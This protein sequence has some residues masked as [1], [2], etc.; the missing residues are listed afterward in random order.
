MPEFT[1]TRNAA[2]VERS[3]KWDL[4]AAIADDAVASALPITSMESKLAAKAAFESV[5]VDYADTTIRDLCTTAR[6]DHDATDEQR[7][8]WRP[9]GW[10]IAR[11]FAMAGWSQEAAADWF[12]SIDTT[13]TQ[14]LANAV[15]RDVAG[16]RPEPAPPAI[17]DAW[18]E[19]LNAATRLLMGGARLAERT[20]N[21][22][23]ELGAHS[24]MARVVYE[25][26]TERNLDAEL[27]ELF[28]SVESDA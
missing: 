15:I 8:S 9:F 13:P 18:R 10:S 12:R 2:Q 22:N 21:E 16:P 6:F 1:R 7:R 26:M 25:R 4:I 11:Q 28:A 27:R 5:G 17:D 20:D 3:S 14:R 24:A 23:I 19:W